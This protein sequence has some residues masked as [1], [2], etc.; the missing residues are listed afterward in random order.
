VPKIFIRLGPGSLGL[1]GPALPDMWLKVTKILTVVIEH[2]AVQ[3]KL[4]SNR[5]KT[6]TRL[7]KYGQTLWPQTL[8]LY[9]SF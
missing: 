1:S 5:I 8:V 6:S 7:Q 2:S 9:V 4:C 3:K